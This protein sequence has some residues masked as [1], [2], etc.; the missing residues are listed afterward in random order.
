MQLMKLLYRCVKRKKDYNMKKKI[1]EGI[2][3]LYKILKKPEMAILP[4]NIAFN[5][6]LA[7]IPIITL[8]VLIASSFDISI[9]T[10]SNLI[11]EF[12]PKQVSDVIISTISGKG[13][14][15]QVGFFNIFAI[16]IASNGMYALI[17]TSDALYKIDGAK[18]LNKRI[19]SI[20]ILFIVILL[21]LF[22]LIVPVFGENILE[23]INYAK[24]F[25]KYSYIVNSIFDIL[26]WPLTLLIIYL[27]INLIYTVAPSVNIKNRDTRIGAI[28]TTFTWTLLTVI[29]RFYLTYFA[30]YDI[31][32]GNLSSIIIMMVWIYFLSYIFTFGMAIN[33][34]IRDQ[35]I[36]N[37]KDENKV[38][39]K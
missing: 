8:V 23:L 20:L 1:K 11:S 14:D 12:M 9:D 27:N 6:I 2:S 18:E 36:N 26:K 28:F 15:N 4:S 7:I 17:N 39:Q 24:V 32:Y 3:K 34:F 38:D 21:F 31:L 37:E 19:S 10:V 22:L 35:A 5:L 33:V 25:G 30:R 16:V 13:F 29:F